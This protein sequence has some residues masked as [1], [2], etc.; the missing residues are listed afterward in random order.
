MLDTHESV[1]AFLEAVLPEFYDHA[2]EYGEPGYN[3]SG[4]NT[5]MVV[6]GSYWCR[7]DKFGDDRMHDIARHY[8]HAFERLEENGVV[9]EWYDEWMVD[10]H[11]SK[12]YRTQSDS[13]HWKPS[14]ILTE[15]GEWLTPDDELETWI[16]WCANDS[17]RCLPS[18][19]YDGSDLESV[20]FERWEGT[21]ESGWHPHQTDDPATIESAIRAAHEDTELDIVF[22]LDNVGQFDMRFSAYF[23][24][25]ES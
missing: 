24:P 12:A 3:L 1:I 25:T 18:N 7:C 17:T 9:F 21:F 19:L 4:D 5:P 11:T 8:P 15:D 20:G 13:Y 6:L 22:V 10:Y 14:V 23:R 16:D 2:A